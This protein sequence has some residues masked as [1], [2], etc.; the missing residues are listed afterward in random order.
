MKNVKRILALFLCICMVAACWSAEPLQAASTLYTSDDEENKSYTLNGKKHTIC[1]EDDFATEADYNAALGSYSLH[2]YKIPWSADEV[3]ATKEKTTYNALFYGIKNAENMQDYS[4]IADVKMATASGTYIALVAHGAKNSDTGNGATGYEFGITNIS[5]KPC[6]RLYQ[7]GGAAKVLEGTNAAYPVA[8]LIADYSAG[9]TVV[10]MRIDIYTEDEQVVIKCSAAKKGEELVEIFTHTDSTSTR[11][12]KG[13]PGFRTN[14]DS[15]GTID[16]VSI[17][18][19]EDDAA[20]MYKDD[21][22]YAEGYTEALGVAITSNHMNLTE[23]NNLATSTTNVNRF[24]LFEGVESATSLTN[25]TVSADFVYSAHSG[26]A[27][28]GV[29]AYGE[30]NE[31]K[32]TYG[33][34][35]AIVG[36]YF[37]LYRRS[38]SAT[39][40]AG[41]DTTTYEVATYFPEYAAGDTIRLSLTAISNSDGSATLICKAIYADEEQMIFNSTDSSNNLTCGTPGLRGNLKNS[42]ADNVVV[43]TNAQYLATLS[44]TYADTL[45]LGTA[46]APYDIPMVDK[47]LAAYEG[48]DILLDADTI[49]ALEAITAIRDY[50]DT[51]SDDTIAASYKTIYEADKWDVETAWNVYQRLSA[52]QK[53]LLSDT[54]TDLVTSMETETQRTGNTI[55][56]GWVGDTIPTDLTSKLVDVDGIYTYSVAEFVENTNYDMVILDQVVSEDEIHSYMGIENTPLVVVTTNADTEEVGASNLQLAEKYALPWIDIYAYENGG[57]TDVAE[58]YADAILSMEPLFATEVTMGFA[59]D[60]NELNSFL[61]PELFSATIKNEPLPENQ[62]LGFKTNI[63]EY[64]KTGTKVEAYGTIFAHYSNGADAEMVLENVKEENTKYIKAEREVSDD[65]GVYGSSYIAGVNRRTNTEF[66]VIYIARSYVKY[67]DGSVYYSMNTR[68]DLQSSLDTRTGVVNGYAS[69]ALTGVARNMVIALAERNIDISSVGTYDAGSKTLTFNADATANDAK[70]IFELLCNNQVILDNIQNAVYLASTGNDENIGTQSAPVAT[71]EKALELVT[72]EGV[73]WVD[74]TVD[75]ASDF[76]WTERDR[77]ITITGDGTLDF[78]ETDDEGNIVWR[79]LILGDDVTFDNVGLAFSTSSAQ[80]NTTSD[81]IYANGHTLVIEEGVEMTGLIN[82][83]GGGNGTDVSSTN[84][85]L[86][87]GNYRRI[88]GGC[89]NATVENNTY[90]YI[91]GNVNSDTDVSSHSHGNDIYGGG[92]GNSSVVTGSTNVTMT[93]KAKA[94]YLLGGCRG[95]TGK[96]GTTNVHVDENSQITSLFG[97]NDNSP[98]ID[99]TYVKV[100]GGTIEQLFG[101]I[102][103]SNNAIGAVS[104]TKGVTID[105]LGGKITR[106]VYG[107]CYNDYDTNITSSTFGQWKTSNYVNGTIHMNISSGIDISLD[108]IDPDY[109]IK[110]DD[111]SI[112]ACSRYKEAFEDEYCII[113]FLDATAA[114]MYEDC[115]GHNNTA[116][117]VDGVSPYDEIITLGQ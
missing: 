62:G 83:Y 41:K 29:I 75:V 104:M 114:N 19:I 37:R 34:E 97:G 27:Y 90:L 71:L 103:S 107:G 98:Y 53:A 16:N 22:S 21:F 5:S 93:G 72:D 11:F 82:L 99:G 81:V 115:L 110:Y 100:T 50:W 86:K 91:G 35:F 95:K 96:V 78:S 3:L 92:D 102:Q 25:Y 61:L 51:T 105:L 42:T 17:A 9:T 1:Y 68:E 56:I 89:Y 32:L 2:P 20:Y 79:T 24:A 59:Y 80:T 18:S 7:R 39:I 60:V 69:R 54:Y 88:F 23:D 101:A 6:F 66:S 113:T 55:S 65:S 63:S 111:R 47:M 48:L 28:N 64:K 57:G 58:I 14:E 73:I 85:T 76:T 112:F 15:G 8:N 84:V 108:A 117:I 67:A 40:L 70:L 46:F 109:G 33:Y 26:S 4:I 36:D 87:E 45:A 49:A 116:S 74:D 52:E 77:E 38:T 106:R 30:P 44:A 10:T 31:S 13:V 12:E 94:N 43:Q